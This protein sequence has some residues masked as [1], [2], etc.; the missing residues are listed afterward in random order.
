MAQMSQNNRGKEKGD[1]SRP[2]AK[3]EG[4]KNIGQGGEG[5]NREKE[6]IEYVDDARGD[7]LLESKVE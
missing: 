1:K 4:T 2:S 5:T 6:K 3:L 7:H